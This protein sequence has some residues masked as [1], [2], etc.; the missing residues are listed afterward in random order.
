MDPRDR[1]LSTFDTYM[2]LVVAYSCFS[3][4]YFTAFEMPPPSENMLV[5]WLENLVFASFLLDIFFNFMRIPEN[6]DEGK[7]KDHSAVA[8]KYMKSGQFFLD[9][10]ATFPFY[11]FP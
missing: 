5:F 3:A 8:K 4:A 7:E 6:E 10:L 2:L 9:F 11:L 1:F